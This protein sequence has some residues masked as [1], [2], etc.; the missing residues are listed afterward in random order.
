MNIDRNN[1][2]E[3]F[4]EF[5]GRDRARDAHIGTVRA[6]DADRA[7]TAELLRRHYI[8]GRLDAQEFEE[9]VGRCYAAR[10]VAELNELVVDL[11]RHELREV[12]PAGARTGRGPVG[13]LVMVAP[14]VAVLAVL[15][16]LTGAHVVWPLAFFILRAGLWRGLRGAWW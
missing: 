11:P 15:A 5:S 13:R 1:Y 2:T 7:A 14:L 8:A 16:G 9:R 10:E 3:Q 6:S 4:H 12:T